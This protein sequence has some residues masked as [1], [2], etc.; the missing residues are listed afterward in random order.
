M[1]AMTGSAASGAVARQG[2]WKVNASNAFASGSSAAGIAAMFALLGL[3]ADANLKN[4]KATEASLAEQKE[5]NR[6][7]REQVDA[8][9][10]QVAENKSA[11]RINRHDI[12]GVF[13]AITVVGLGLVLAGKMAYKM[14]TDRNLVERIIAIDKQLARLVAAGGNTALIARLEM[15]KQNLEARL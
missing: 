10:N 8:N 14:W 3:Q 7:I 11:I 12:K 6:I 13:A 9:S 4:Q 1:G 2:R 5:G 15:E